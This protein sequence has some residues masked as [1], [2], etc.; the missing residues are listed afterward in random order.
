MTVV[1]FVPSPACELQGRT[2]NTSVQ[3]R[4][5]STTVFGIL[6]PGLGKPAPMSQGQPTPCAGVSSQPCQAEGEE[7]ER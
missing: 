4:G 6:A 2:S 7:E 3:P 5:A 1:R